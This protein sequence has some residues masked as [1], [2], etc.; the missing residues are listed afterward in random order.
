MA[1]GPA[2]V[3]GCAPAAGGSAGGGAVS[4]AA[5]RRSR[6][7]A[8]P[9][10]DSGFGHIQ[11]RWDRRLGRYVA[12]ILPGEYYA[13][14]QDEIIT[15]VLGSCVSACI[16]DPAAGVGGMN[17]FMLPASRDG[18]DVHGP[19]LAARYGNYAMEALINAILRA[20]GRR[21][22]LV[23]KVFGGGRIISSLTNVGRLNIAFMREYIR[24]EGLRLEAED[25]GGP[26][27]RKVEF[28]PAT[29]RVRVKKLR[30]L[31]ATGVVERE[32]HYL[33]DLEEEPVEG[34]IELFE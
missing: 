14:T 33:H 1:P 30:A 18:A 29:G 12:R 28:F 34:E 17:H 5:A 27:P 6:Q 15:T 10:D 3:R 31:Q 21:E 22:T 2:R 20:R 11:R 4:G 26:W 23:V 16:Y 7:P 25:V 32:T 19:S 13:T 9:A 8:P 24:T